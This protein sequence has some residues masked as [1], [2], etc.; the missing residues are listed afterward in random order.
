MLCPHMELEAP[1]SGALVTSARAWSDTVNRRFFPLEIVP[2]RVHDFWARIDVLDHGTAQSGLIHAQGHGVRR[3]SRHAEGADDG[4]FKAFWLIDGRCEIAQGKNRALLEPGDWTVYDTTRPYSIEIGD[5]S[6]FAVLLLPHEAC[7][8]W[9]AIGSLLCGDRLEADPA[10]RGALFALLSMFDTLPAGALQGSEPVVDAMGRLLSVSLIDQACRRL[11]KGNDE[12]RLVEARRYILTC[13]DDPALTP[14]RLA[15]AMNMSRR[16]LYALFKRIGAT[17]GGLILQTR[18][19]RCRD[20]LA[21]PALRHRT[22]TEIALDNGF[23]DSAHFS[24]LFKARFGLP[25]RQ[26]RETHCR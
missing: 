21:N 19:D 1:A 25:P 12:R 9:G 3:T 8:Q 6:R 16:A 20:A 24:R 2:R 26:W 5:D 23:G 11:P 13:V 17:P 7:M 10:S 4:Y 22:V 14:E 15:K 18:L